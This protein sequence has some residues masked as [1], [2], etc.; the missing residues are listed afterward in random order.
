MVEAVRFRF[1]DKMIF[2]GNRFITGQTELNQ[3]TNN[4]QEGQFLS[5]SAEELLVD[6]LANG[7]YKHQRHL[8][9]LSEHH[10]GSILKIRFVLSPFTFVFLL[11][12]ENQYHIIMETLDTEEATYIW[13]VPK[14]IAELKNALLEV[15]SDLNKIRNEGRQEFLK[16]APAISAGY[17][18]TIRMIAKG[19]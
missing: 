17:F 8:R 1:S 4:G 11:A 12:G 7:N 2:N 13:H 19:L 5:Q 16:S 6:A 3:E 9:Y 10:D 14:S 18:T 15:E